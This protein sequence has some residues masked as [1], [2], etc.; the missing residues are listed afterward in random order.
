MAE[1]ARWDRDTLWPKYNLA[2]RIALSEVYGTMSLYDYEVFAARRGRLPRPAKTVPD[3]FSCT[4]SCNVKYYILRGDQ[5]LP[6]EERIELDDAVEDVSLWACRQWQPRAWIVHRVEV[7]DGGEADGPGEIRRRTDRV[8]VD[9]D[10]RRRDLFRSAVVETDGR[11]DVLRPN[12]S[13]VALPLEAAESCRVTHYD[14][15]CVQVEA[16]LSQPGLVVLCDQFY[17]GWRVEVETVGS[18]V[19]GPHE[20]RHYERPILRTNRVMRGVWLTAGE[21]H[22]TYRYRPAS[23]LVGGAITAL[24]W[25]GLMGFLVVCRLRAR[26]PQNGHSLTASRA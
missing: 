24:A 26:R 2:D 22:L 19:Q 5:R 10:G 23:V 13:A 17:P 1:A 14:P 3:T 12:N 20:C 7:L 25:L 18:G 6:G 21:H 11:S 9:T 4:F 8:F 15:L 16:T